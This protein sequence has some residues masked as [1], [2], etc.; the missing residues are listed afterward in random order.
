MSFQNA[1]AIGVDF[2]RGRG[3]AG[4]VGQRG[5]ARRSP[6]SHMNERVGNGLD[7]APV[8]QQTNFDFHAAVTFSSEIG[9]SYDIFL[10]KGKLGVGHAARIARQQSRSTRPACCAFGLLLD[11]SGVVS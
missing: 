3:L 5:E 8:M 7:H 6:G 11:R 10:H 9:H 4:I 1:I 2:Q